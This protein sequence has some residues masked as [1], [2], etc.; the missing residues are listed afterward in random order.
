TLPVSRLTT[1]PG[2]SDVA[3]TSVSIIAGSGCFSLATTTTVFPVTMTGATT[4]TS[5]SK[6]EP[7]GATMPTTPVGSGMEKS[8]YGPATGLDEPI[9]WPTLS[10][11]PA[12]QTQ[13]S[14]AASTI[15]SAL[16]AETPSA[17]ATSVANC[18]RRPS[19][20]SAMR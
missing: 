8:K 5:P 11:Q 7:C 1:P 3:N 2:R 13:R 10:D 14:I 16:A 18:S 19:S 20:I 6:L 9:T 17:A 12:Y 15:D 4:D